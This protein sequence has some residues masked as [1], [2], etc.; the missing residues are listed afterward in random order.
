MFSL[1]HSPQ[2]LAV[3]LPPVY[4]S[5]LRNYRIGRDELLFGEEY[6]HPVYEEKLTLARVQFLA[7]PEHVSLGA[8]FSIEESDAILERND[9]IQKRCSKG[10][11][12]IGE[13]ATGHSFFLLG[14]VED[15]LDQIMI[16]SPELTFP[17]GNEITKVSPDIYSFINGFA[18]VELEEGI[19][20]GVSGYDKVFKNWG[21]DF[22]QIRK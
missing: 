20:D 6:N 15:N 12:L 19:G 8:M 13:D 14:I 10:Y 11:R 9:D 4:A 3:L 7:N 2:E 18:L 17:G 22:W 1:F 16:Y 5:L 21:E